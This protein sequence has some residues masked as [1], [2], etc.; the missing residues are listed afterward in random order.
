VFEQERYI[1]ARVQAGASLSRIAREFV[2]L[3]AAIRGAMKRG[4]LS[5]VP[6]IKYVETAEDQRD[7]EPFGRP[8]SMQEVAAIFNAAKTA[9][10]RLFLMILANTLCRPGAA[11]ELTRFQVDFEHGLVNLNRPGRKQTKKFR[12]IVPMTG[13]LRPWLE[14]PGSDRYLAYGSQKV[15]TAKNLWRRLRAAAG[16]SGDVN[17]Y[18]IRHTM[19]R[20][21]RKR[22]VPT[23]QI[24]LMLGHR[25]PDKTT[26]RYAPYH[27]DY[28][29]DAA[30][31]IDAYMVDLQ[32]LVASPIV[33]I[34]AAP[35]LR[36][37]RA[38]G[39]GRD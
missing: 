11:L 24:E 18:S 38:G 12:P 3:R 19:A 17:S 21:L 28:C 32:K 35:K 29:Q 6:F 30:S 22:R 15:T 27:P 13:A 39:R 2:T 9:R 25:R 14:A 36:V 5:T 1:A 20:E 33:G 4:E 8:L 26:Q 23:E 31:A 37:V 7:D 10:T 34:M 16:L